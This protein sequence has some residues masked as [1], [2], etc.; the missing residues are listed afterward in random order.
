MGDLERIYGLHAV[1][2]VLTRDPARVVQLTLADRRDDRRIAEIEALARAAG[3][4]TKRVHGD[5]R[6]LLRCC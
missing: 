5:T 2:A 1:R 6:R 3:V 4:T